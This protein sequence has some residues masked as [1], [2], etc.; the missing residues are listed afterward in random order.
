MTKIKSILILLVLITPIFVLFFSFKQSNS[1]I[2]AIN[3]S[4]PNTFVWT[5]PDDPNTQFIWKNVKVTA[6]C[7]NK[8]CCGDFADGITAGGQFAIGYF[9]AAPRGILFNTKMI[10][11][12]YN[13]NLPV[14]V[15]DRGF[16][17]HGNRLDVFFP[18]HIEALIWGV[19]WLDI[20]IFSND[21]E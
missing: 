15:F 18:T 3:N 6:Y 20:I 5:L 4:D 14:R 19:Q 7:P 21:K 11:P 12:R 13:D 9:T 2:I 8:C 1:S 17:I 16:A 10:V